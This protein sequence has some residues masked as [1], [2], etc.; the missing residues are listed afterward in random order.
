MIYWILTPVQ[1]SRFL[2]RLFGVDVTT[3]NTK[4]GRQSYSG[5]FALCASPIDEY[6]ETVTVPTEKVGEFEHLLERG[7]AA[8]LVFHVLGKEKS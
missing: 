1:E 3:K 7:R 6:E 4:T 8:G 5:E 2:E